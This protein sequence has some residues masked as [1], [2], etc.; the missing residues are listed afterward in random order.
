VVEGADAEPELPAQVHHLSHLVGA[1]AVVLHQDPPAQDFRQGLEPEVAVRL[2]IGPFLEILVPLPPVFLRLRERRAVPGDVGH[3]G[4]GT[5]LGVHA[6]GVFA[7]GHLEAVWRAGILHFL[8][9]PRRNESQRRRAAADEVG[10]A[11]EHLDHRHTA[12][13]RQ[14]DLRVLGPERMLGP[15][16]RGDRVG[17]LVTVAQAPGAG[18]GV[19]ADVAV[20]VDKSGSDELA[21]AVY[22]GGLGR[23]YGV[24]AH[25]DDLAVRQQN[26]GVGQ[27]G[28]GRGQDGRVADQNWR[29][30]TPGVGRGILRA[31]DAERVGRR[32]GAA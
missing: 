30:L 12:G 4:G 26:G 7:A 8:H 11:G 23:R 25:R 16:L 27:F 29:V 28:S 9:R 14:G 19:D 6:L 24:A 2:L 22:H 17:S 3:A 15:H 20:G 5:L 1:V 31:T 13:D 32:R 10:G 18:G 21:R